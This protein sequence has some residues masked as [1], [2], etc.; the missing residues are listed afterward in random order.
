MFGRFAWAPQ[1][2]ADASRSA[3]SATALRQAMDV[4]SLFTVFFPR[5]LG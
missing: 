3:A 4:G 2:A 1:A 5:K